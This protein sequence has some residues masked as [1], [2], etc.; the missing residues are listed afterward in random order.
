[1]AV[2]AAAHAASL[3]QLVER[4]IALR[5]KKS[6]LKGEYE[7]S[8]AAIEQGLEKIENFL[9]KQLNDSGSESVRTKAG[10]FFKSKRYSATAADWA[11]VSDWVQEDPAE[12]WAILE[13]RV[14]KGFVEAY[15]EAHNDLPPGVDVRIETTV[16]VRRS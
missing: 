7:K 14:S 5:D 13:K 15:Q 12:R 10:T 9:L 16:N 2:E 6:E 3:D 1:M 11:M 4:Y 8:V